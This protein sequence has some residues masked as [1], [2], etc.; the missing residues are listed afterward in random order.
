[1]NANVVVKVETEDEV[2]VD[3]VNDEVALKAKAVATNLKTKY[4]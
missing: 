1:M 3:T 4:K 2:K